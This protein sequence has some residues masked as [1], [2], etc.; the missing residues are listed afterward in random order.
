METHQPETDF[1]NE[2]YKRQNYFRY[3]T[4]LYAAYVSSL[5]TFC[6]LRDGDSLLDVGC[7]QGLFSYLF[8][9][10]NLKVRGIDISETGV[11]AA[12]SLYGKFG[13]T[14]AVEDIRTPTYRQAFD[15]VFVRSCSLYNTETF[16]VRSDITQNLLHLLKENGALIFIYNSNCSSKKSLTWRYHSLRD[17]KEHFSHYPDAQIFF[18]NRL[19]SFLLRRYS[20]SR[21]IT[22]LNILLSSALGI[23]GE[24]V[25]ILK[26]ARSR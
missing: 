18:I 2:R 13:V 12:V 5:V 7:G 10:H 25:C 8:C 11:R 9:K 21:S 6:G 26:K 17:V 14:F 3:S 4:W 24:I 16:P 19:T 1:Y 23:G 22:R 15:C 20:F